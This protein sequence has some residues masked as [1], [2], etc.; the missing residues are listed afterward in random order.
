VRRE[1]GFRKGKKKEEGEECAARER[2]RRLFGDDFGRHRVRKDQKKLPKKE[3]REERGAPGRLDAS[4]KAERASFP[5]LF[6][7]RISYA[8][9]EGK[10]RK[11]K[12]RRI[13]RDS[14]SPRHL[15]VFHSYLSRFSSGNT[16]KRK[17][18]GRKSEKRK[19]GNKGRIAC[20]SQHGRTHDSRK[21]N[22]NP[23]G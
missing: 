2:P 20:F 8:S 6:H 17:G 3:G 23:G 15:L 11:K 14:R 21:V 22:R 19:R 12:K 9:A 7:K 1:E 13:G 16:G 10:T 5:P 18:K 4:P